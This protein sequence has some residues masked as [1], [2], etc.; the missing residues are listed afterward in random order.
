MTA[1]SEG[2]TLIRVGPWG[3]IGLWAGETLLHLWVSLEFKIGAS[4]SAL[5]GTAGALARNA[6]QARKF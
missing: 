5:T 3:L 6:P 2:P 1:R 4:I